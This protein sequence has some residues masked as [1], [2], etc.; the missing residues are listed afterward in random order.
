[1]KPKERYQSVEEMS[2]DLKLVLRS[3]PLST[4]PSKTNPART[5][6]PHSTQPD[7]P[8]LFESMQSSQ[9]AKDQSSQ[10]SSA[11]VPSQQSQTSVK[12]VS[13]TRCPRC[14]AEIRR[15]ATF[16][17]QCGFSLANKAPNNL[18]TTTSPQTPA[19]IPQKSINSSLEDSR[20]L[21]GSSDETRMSSMP[22]ISDTFSYSA[23]NPIQES[24]VSPNTMPSNPGQNIMR[25]QLKPSV[26]DRVFSP[27][28]SQVPH[29]SFMKT[30]VPT[31][32]QVPPNTK[33]PIAVITTKPANNVTS[34]ETRKILLY[35]AIVFIVVLLIVMFIALKSFAQH[36]SNSTNHQRFAIVTQVCNN[37]QNISLCITS[38]APH[39]HPG[40]WTRRT[41]VPSTISVSER[42]VGSRIRHSPGDYWNW[43]A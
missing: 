18:A 22:K 10:D 28:P 38:T 5:I 40:L 37:E 41:G 12:S 21:P 16:C 24:V 33:P 6:D 1:M 27:A 23:G 25:T 2:N 36:S 8:Q 43:F 39:P 7:L 35:M 32:V 19:F 9:A 3:L 29:K 11:S 34:T 13:L 17:P 30:S 26:Q 20:V 31:L 14:N 15:Q 4:Q 42:V